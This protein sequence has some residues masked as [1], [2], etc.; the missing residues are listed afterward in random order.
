MSAPDYEA[1]GRRAV[2]CKHWRWM[3]GMRCRQWAGDRSWFRIADGTAHTG[4]MQPDFIDPATLGCLLALVRN[5]WGERVH[6]IHRT[7]GPI[8]EAWLV[9]H[10]KGNPPWFGFSGPTES[11]AL[12][13]ALEAAP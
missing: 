12:V 7:D 1:L 2:T 5:V 9:C 13:A 4:N 11:E 3:P 6:V 8:R 10:R